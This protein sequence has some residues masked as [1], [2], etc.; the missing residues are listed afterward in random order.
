MKPW[1]S[2]YCVPAAYI[3]SE[4]K[5]SH[6]AGKPYVSGTHFAQT[7]AGPY[8]RGAVCQ[9]HMFRT[10]FFIIIIADKGVLINPFLSRSGD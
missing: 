8:G 10:D 1:I 5:R 7:E 9:K 4:P 3:L 6:T 2:V